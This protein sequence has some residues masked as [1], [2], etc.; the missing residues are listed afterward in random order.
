MLASSAQ[1]VAV[2]ASADD[3][4]RALHLR[5]RPDLFELRL[6]ALYPICEAIAAAVPR[7]RAA[8]IVTARHPT[9]G[10]MN[11]L[12][13]AQR[14]DLLIRFL[15]FAAF[16]DIELRSTTE[17]AVV[18][19]RAAESRVRRILSVHNFTATP[20]RA[21]LD[22]FARAA[23]EHDADILKI[24]TRITSDNDAERLAQFLAAEQSR[25][26]ISITPIG[27]RARALRLAF[28]RQGSALNYAHL[29]VPQADGQW[30]FATF[31]R[32]LSKRG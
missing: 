10:G 3:L 22:Q 7:L 4:Q 6:D 14:R 25:L 21:E 19:Q 1:I 18:L 23:R 28:A 26:P 11:R 29:G 32:A 13:A 2:I 30:S 8:V 27:K 24:A 16:I 17:L 20:S 15:P 5:R 9:E 31:R 12:A